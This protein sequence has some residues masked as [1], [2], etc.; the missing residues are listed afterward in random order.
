MRAGEGQGDG[1]ARRIGARRRRGVGSAAALLV[2]LGVLFGQPGAAQARTSI[3]FCND[4]PETLHVAMATE[5][6]VE[7][8]EVWSMKGW[9]AL[10]PGRCESIAVA[11]PN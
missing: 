4:R 2:G 5:Y 8:R 1:A 7:G 11:R 6:T 3:V 10:K 9:L